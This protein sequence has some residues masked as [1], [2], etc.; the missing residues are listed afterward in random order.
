M[1]ACM[2]H[3]RAGR[4]LQTQAAAI[5]DKDTHILRLEERVLELEAAVAG[6]AAASDEPSVAMDASV[7]VPLSAVAGSGGLAGDASTAAPSSGRGQLARAISADRAAMPDWESL[8]VPNTFKEAL[9]QILMLQVRQP[10][11]LP[12][13]EATP[14]PSTAC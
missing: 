6:A 14:P 8:P 7:T 5:V 10:R 13:P 1:T 3:S 9:E 4:L 12:P 11:L 2:R